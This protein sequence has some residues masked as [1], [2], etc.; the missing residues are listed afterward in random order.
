MLQHK[1]H[2]GFSVFHHYDNSHEKTISK[3]EIVK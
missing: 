1:S 3:V 2:N